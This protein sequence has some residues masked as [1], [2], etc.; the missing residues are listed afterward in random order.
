[1]KRIRAIGSHWNYGP[2]FSFN[3]NGNLNFMQNVL[4]QLNI[5]DRRGVLLKLLSTFQHSVSIIIMLVCFT[6]MPSIT[7]H[8]SSMIN[9][10]RCW[11]QMLMLIKYTVTHLQ[12]LAKTNQS[13]R[14]YWLQPIDIVEFSVSIS[15]SQ[16]VTVF[17]AGWRSLSWEVSAASQIFK[18]HTYITFAPCIDYSWINHTN[19][20]AMEFD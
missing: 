17:W 16:S 7:D 15:P 4:P 5:Y 12:K 2:G 20:N 18:I 1:M 8:F 10:C 6:W 13:T 19:N 11:R 3:F 9:R 14:R